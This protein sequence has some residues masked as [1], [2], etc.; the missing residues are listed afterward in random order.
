MFKELNVVETVGMVNKTIHPLE[1]R[2]GFE[3]LKDKT[4][5]QKEVRGLAD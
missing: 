1:I 5:V 4:V 2:K 3:E